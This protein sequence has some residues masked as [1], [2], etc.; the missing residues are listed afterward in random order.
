MTILLALFALLW[1]PRKSTQAWFLKDE[2][3][4]WMEERMSR[5]SGGQD[6]SALGITK[7]DIVETLKDWKFCERRI[8]RVGE[9]TN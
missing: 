7:T 4:A 9:I 1:L 3:K 5:D 2:E 6:Q 8:L